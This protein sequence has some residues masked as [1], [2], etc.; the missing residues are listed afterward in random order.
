MVRQHGAPNIVATRDAALAQGVRPLGNTVSHVKYLN[1]IKGDNA[2]L[3][4]LQAACLRVTSGMG[5]PP[6][7][8]GLI[9]AAA[10]VA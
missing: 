2:R 1:E 9:R 10:S 4:D 8:S 6:L 5:R 7:D 3:G